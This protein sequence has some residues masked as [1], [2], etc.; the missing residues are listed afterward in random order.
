MPEEN[1][2]HL[3]IYNQLAVLSKLYLNKHEAD[4]IAIFTCLILVLDY[5][6]YI[7]CKN[8]AL[9]SNE[10]GVILIQRFAF[11]LKFLGKTADESKLS[12]FGC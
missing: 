2:K 9:V 6:K 5:N 3:Q 8:E 12:V 4:P 11:M 10:C 1:T 7:Q